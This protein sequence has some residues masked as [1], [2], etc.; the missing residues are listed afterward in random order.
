MK[1][2]STLAMLAGLCV[3]GPVAAQYG[4]QSTNPG[5]PSTA[6]TAAPEARVEGKD[7][8]FLKQAA[9]NGRAEVEASKLAQT[10]ATQADVKAFAAKMVEDHQQAHQELAQ[11]A[12]SKGVKLPDDPSLMQRGRLKMLSGADGE[13]FDKRYAEDFGVKAHEDTVK[14]FKNAAAN[15][16]DADVKAFAQKTLPKLEEHLTMARSM[17]AAVVPTAAGKSDDRGAKSATTEPKKQ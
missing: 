5:S 14:M 6:K 9:Q 15:A 2:V 17:E 11:L 1:V 12:Q 10:K 8:D 16:K 3:A 13:K 7:A 4:Q